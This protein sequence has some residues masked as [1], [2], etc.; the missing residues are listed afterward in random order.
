MLAS[1]AKKDINYFNA[2]HHRFLADEFA[3]TLVEVMI[4]DDDQLCTALQGLLKICEI[5]SEHYKYVLFYF[6]QVITYLSN[7]I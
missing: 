7:L 5:S 2:T 1:A 3:T 4:D 6:V